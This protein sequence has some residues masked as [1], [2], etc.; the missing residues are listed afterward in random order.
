MSTCVPYAVHVLTGLPFESVMEKAV[1]LGWSEEGLTD[2]GGWW[3]LKQCGCEVTPI[4]R[5]ENRTTF[6]AA[7]QGLDRS[8]SYV[9][10]TKDHWI[11][12]RNGE[13]L[14]RAS[15]PPGERIRTRIELLGHSLG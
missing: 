8:R 4:H 1:A 7:V 13:V 10:A 5:Y 2:I 3:L 14:Y 6:R 11:A 12:V 9:L 15:T